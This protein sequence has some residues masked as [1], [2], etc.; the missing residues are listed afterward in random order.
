MGRRGEGEGRKGRLR[1]ERCLRCQMY[2]LS[3]AS[4]CSDHL[5]LSSE[6]MAAKSVRV[7]SA[8]PAIIPGEGPTLLGAG[9]RD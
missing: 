4:S 5:V 9:G 7:C 2:H 8:R 1:E 6:N 3:T